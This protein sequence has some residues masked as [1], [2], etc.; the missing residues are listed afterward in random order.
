MWRHIVG[1]IMAMGVLTAS[2]GRTP[3]DQRF[4][5]IDDSLDHAFDHPPAEIRA[6]CAAEQ[7][8]LRS[9]L[10][11][12]AA[13]PEA[14]ATFARTAAEL[15]AATAAFTNNLGTVLFLKQVSP[16][17]EVRAAAD[18][19]EIEV[20]RLNVEIYGRADLYRA[21][22]AA[23]AKREGLDPQDKQLLDEL[24]KTFKRNGLE[25]DPEKRKALAG[26]RKRLVELES[27]FNTNLGEHRDALVVTREELAGLPESYIERLERT[28]DGKY[29]VTVDY[30]QYYPFME[31]AKDAGAR[32]RL[33]LKFAQRGGVRNKELLEQ[34]IRIRHELAVALGYA[35]HADYVQEEMMAKE[36][37]NVQ[38][39]L[40]SLVRALRPLGEAELSE[41]RAEKRKD[42][43]AGGAD[44]IEAWDYTYYANQI[45][46]KRYG[47]DPEE[48]RQYFPLDVVLRAMFDVYETVLGVRFVPAE[49]PT[50]HESARLYR[51]V[52]RGR[53]RAYFYTDL[54]PREGKYRHAAT[55]PLL[56]G[57]RQQS[58]AYRAP[59][60]AIVAN[61]T[62]PSGGES[63]LLGHDEVETLFHEFGHVVHELLTEARYARFSGTNVRWDFVETPSGMFE[64]WVWDP[65]ILRRMTA[66]RGD[67]ARP[68]PE[69]MIDK[70]VASRRH[71]AGVSYLRQAAL[72]TV[73]LRYHTSPR[74]DS[75]AEYARAMR[76]IMGVPIQEGTYPEA[77]FGH[78]MSGYDA[79]Y[80]SY[81]WSESYAADLFTRFDREG[82]LN[83]R[84]GDEFRGYI[85]APG[86]TREPLDLMT[87]FLGRRPSQEAFWKSLGLGQPPAGPAPEV[88]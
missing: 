7:A 74:V 37:E 83:P 25:L 46:K 75:T 2:C 13:V 14:Q 1:T 34:A 73:D 71:G 76:D 17:R 54:F 5:V 79:R 22:R 39:F 78:L 35:N 60:A 4:D 66:Y 57:M 63:P 28:E 86:G 80:Y 87:G 49:G 27:E 26:Q 33:Q 43:I 15:E 85:L 10:D 3:I 9:R 88:R 16:S 18:A 52:D 6:L 31:N 12:V 23:A 50:W 48:L 56:K 36:P 81:L 68:M 59:V 47:L 20:G 84:T 32:R 55:F 72:A 67:K 45:R 11:R 61:F 30:P 77:S 24:L 69:A 29:R 65:Q 21:L 70:L 82:L 51:V 53:T 58:G 40:D 42:A 64:S 41:M 38:R 62:P 44:R 19:C 8:R